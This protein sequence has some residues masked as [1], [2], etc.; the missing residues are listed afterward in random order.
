MWKKHF[1]LLSLSV[2][3]IQVTR[4]VHVQFDTKTNK[5]LS[6]KSA[7]GFIS[8]KLCNDEKNVPK[9]VILYL[10]FEKRKGLHTITG[11]DFVS[12]TLKMIAYTKRS[13]SG[14]HL[15]LRSL[16]VDGS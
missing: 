9:N 4:L 10:A 15:Q 14:R 7:G 5:L 3:T 8:H 16:E 11:L 1:H 2:P 12:K 13:P 6:I